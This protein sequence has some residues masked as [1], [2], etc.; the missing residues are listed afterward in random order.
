MPLKTM[1]EA[2]TASAKR[3][4][5]GVEGPANARLLCEMVETVRYLRTQAD[6]YEVARI[7][8]ALPSVRNACD[9][10]MFDEAM[11]KL[12]LDYSCAPFNLK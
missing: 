7:R 8:Y 9:S 4:D 3:L 12:R 5:M 10:V 6:R 1:L 11:D 2:L